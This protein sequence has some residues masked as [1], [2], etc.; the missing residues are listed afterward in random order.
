M[1]PLKCLI[2]RRPEPMMPPW[3][4]EA[5]EKRTAKRPPGYKA[6]VLA[7][8]RRVGDGRYQLTKADYDAITRR[9]DIKRPT[10]ASAIAAIAGPAPDFGP[11]TVLHD[12]IK[13]LFGAEAVE[14]CGCQIVIDAMNRWG[15][16]GCRTPG[17]FRM[18]VNHLMRA[19][20]KL[21]LN[22]RNWA[23]RMKQGV[24]IVGKAVTPEAIQ[25]AGLELL[26]KTSIDE[27]EAIQ[28]ERLMAE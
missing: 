4:L 22:A 18:I 17:N 6:A 14:G 21:A 20:N 7:K 2:S 24:A 9:F 15:V 19:R 5:L 1:N 10:L 11:G 3:T 28:R 12:K 8:A 13:A 23:D 27:A 16:E 25:R 26:V